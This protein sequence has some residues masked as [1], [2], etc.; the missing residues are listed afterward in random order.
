MNATGH[1]RVPDAGIHVQVE[2]KAMHA[3]SVPDVESESGQLA[4]AVPNT[5][6]P[7]PSTALDPEICQ[8]GD[9]PLLKSCNRSLDAPSSQVADEVARELPRPVPRRQTA[10]P[11]LN[12]VGPVLSEPSLGRHPLNG[13]LSQRDHGAVLNES[14]QTAALPQPYRLPQGLLALQSFYVGQLTAPPEKLKGHGLTLP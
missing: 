13:T 14:Q 12:Q 5:W 1:D 10:T 11:S 3:D 8:P 9:E 2:R 6:V 4:A 7:F